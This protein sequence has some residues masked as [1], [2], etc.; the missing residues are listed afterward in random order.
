MHPS[1][2]HRPVARLFPTAC[3]IF[4]LILYL[5]SVLQ[6]LILIYRQHRQGGA[7]AG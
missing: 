6:V 2:S 5:F 4:P 3:D 1:S 7:A